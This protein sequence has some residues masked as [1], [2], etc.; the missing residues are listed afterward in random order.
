MDKEE[1]RKALNRAFTLGQVFWQQAVSGSYKQSAKAGA[2]WTTFN[3]LVEETL[4]ALAN[5]CE[6]GWRPIETA[7]KDCPILAYNPVQGVYETRYDKGE[8]PHADW[9]SD[10][11]GRTASLWY[12]RPTHWMPL[13]PP[14]QES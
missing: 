10:D 14:P 4:A 11:A 5:S 8:W 1:L 3:T 9:F 7:P 2:T 12:P 13:P 6:G